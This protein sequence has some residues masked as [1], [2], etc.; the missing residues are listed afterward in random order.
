LGEPINPEA[1]MWYNEVIGHGKCPIVDYVVANRNRH[2]HDP[3]HCR[4]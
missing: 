1:W 4:V 2:D 3:R